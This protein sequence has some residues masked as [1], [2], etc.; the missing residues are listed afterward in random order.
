MQHQ[1]KNKNVNEN[2]LKITKEYYKGR[3]NQSEPQRVV[4]EF[5]KL[6]RRTLCLQLY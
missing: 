4:P 6:T 3:R 1:V 5:L 2:N